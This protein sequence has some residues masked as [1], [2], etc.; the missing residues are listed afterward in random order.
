MLEMMRKAQVLRLCEQLKPPE[1]AER[2]RQEE[3]R[4]HASETVG[5][6]VNL[7]EAAFVSRAEERGVERILRAGWPDFMVRMDGCWIGVEVKRGGDRVSERQR[8]MFEALEQAGIRVYVW[9]PVCPD[10]LL[11]WKTYKRRAK[12]RLAEQYMW[13]KRGLTT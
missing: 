7:S 13:R 11:N 12:S 4:E 5:G 10:R 9:N 6:G 8:V 3:V 2:E 1:V